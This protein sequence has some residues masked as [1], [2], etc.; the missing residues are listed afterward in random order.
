MEQSRQLGKE[1]FDAYIADPTV[2][3]SFFL[4]DI[5]LCAATTADQEVV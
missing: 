5:V 4:S 2:G 3:H 1:R